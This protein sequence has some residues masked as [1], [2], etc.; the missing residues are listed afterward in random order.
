[1]TGVRLLAGILVL[2]ATLPAASS[3]AGAP[4]S[5]VKALARTAAAQSAR[6]SLNERIT[7][8][9]QSSTLRLS[10]VE[11]PRAANGSFTMLIAPAE[12]GLGQVTEVVRGARIY[13]HYPIL[14]TLHAA[15]PRVKTWIVVD[16]ASSLGVDP[17]SLTSLGLQELAEMTGIV[18]LGSGREQG[19]AITRYAGTLSL[20]KAAG[21][22]Q[23]RILLAHLP[24]VAAAVLGSSE[25][26]V[27]SVGADGFV[28]GTSSTIAASQAAGTALRV[29][30][31]ATYSDFDRER[32]PIAAPPAAE[33]MTLARFQQLTTVAPPPADTAL[34][35]RIVLAPSQI[36]AGYTVS[37]IP[38]G[39][40]VQGQV[41][42]DFCGKSYASEALRSARLQVAY[43]AKGRAYSAS[44]EVVTYQNGG[45]QEALR[46]M[47]QAAT[48]CPNGTVTNPP[49]GVSDLVRSTRVLHDRHLLAGSVAI[50]ETDTGVVHGKRVS[51]SSVAVYQVRGRVLSGVYGR[52]G[53]LP[54]LEAQTFHAAEASAARLRREVIVSTPLP[55]A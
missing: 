49:S 5:L 23:I 21:A 31:N 4:P 35:H 44:N 50:L 17:S 39:Q 45:A 10:G 47:A 36:G 9:G 20:R 16:S 37:Q 26:I 14:D 52:G 41:T 25:R 53:P 3:G 34:I 28:H 13:V 24:S 6:V 32:A 27:F 38:G 22:A 51:S 42:L 48:S 15:N 18:R 7:L 12:A 33:V 46:E 2:A 11:Q 40:L 55:I 30:I 8:G 19:M 54:A 43:T 29:V 1:V